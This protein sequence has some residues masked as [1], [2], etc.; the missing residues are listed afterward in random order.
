[1]MQASVSQPDLTIK[2]PEVLKM[3]ISEPH[4]KHTQSKYLGKEPG[5]NLRHC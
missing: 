1:M 5:G 4:P 3:Q 2:S